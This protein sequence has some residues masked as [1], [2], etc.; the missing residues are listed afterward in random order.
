M[1]TTGK[2]QKLFGVT[3]QTVRT[4]TKEFEAHLSPNATPQDKGGK[5]TYTTDD[6]AVFALVVEKTQS[7]AT[8]EDIRKAL[9]NGERAEP[10]E[11]EEEPDITAN[12][13]PREI[14]LLSNITSERDIALGRLE[15]LQ[16]IREKDAQTI[17]RLSK[18]VGKLEN[19]LEEFRKQIK[20]EGKND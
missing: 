2:V 6:I 5:R 18:E 3:G 8:Y 11:F 9:Q 14:I 7:G 12:L 19:Q 15:E 17:E 13:T 16:G 20:K 10:P 4:W 1:L